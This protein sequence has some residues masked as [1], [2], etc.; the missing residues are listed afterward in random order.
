MSYTS[1]KSDFTP[2]FPE[3]MLGTALSFGTSP[4]PRSPQFG[5]TPRIIWSNSTPLTPSPDAPLRLVQLAE[6]IPKAEG[7]GE[8]GQELSGGDNSNPATSQCA[9][10]TGVQPLLSLG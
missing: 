7:N 3:K 8:T 2:L 4:H 9:G 10:R 5:V 1:Q 6:P